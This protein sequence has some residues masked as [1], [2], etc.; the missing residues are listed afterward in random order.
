M[1]KRLKSGIPGFDEISGGGI[2]KGQIILLSGAPGTGKTTMCTQYVYEGLKSHNENGIFLSFEETSE[3]IRKTSAEFGWNFEEFERM[4]KFSFVKYDPYHVEEIFDL[5]ESKIRDTGAHRV[6]ID[7]ISA[8]GLYVRDKAEL[9]RMIFNLSTIL[10]NLDCTTLMVSEIVPGTKGISRHGVE[11][12]VAD[13]VVVLYYERNN[14]A[15]NRA[16]QVWK[17]KSSNHSNKLH[18]YKITENGVKINPAEEA[19]FKE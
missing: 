7:S 1:I 10:R 2:P 18:P 3:S 4:N 8:L 19:Y 16:V 13:G 6:V 9:R 5:L 15:F 12:F 11:E 17:M 14:L